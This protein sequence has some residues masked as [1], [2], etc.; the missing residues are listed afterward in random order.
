MGMEAVAPGMMVNERLIE[1]GVGG[2]WSGVRGG[3][4]VGGEGGGAAM[5][6]MV[7]S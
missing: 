6:A 4:W 2:G 5:T 7:G 1:I 3:T